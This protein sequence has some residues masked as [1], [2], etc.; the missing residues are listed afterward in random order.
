MRKYLFVFLL[1]S[2]IACTNKSN[3]EMESDLPVIDLEKEYPIKRIDIHEIADVEYIPLE[4]I[5]ESILMFGTDKSV[6]DEYIIVSEF[7]YEYK[8]LIFTRNGKYVSTI[9]RQGQGPGEYINFVSFEVDFEKKELFVRT[10]TVA[11]KILVYTLDGKY[12]REFQLPSRNET[13][14]FEFED[15]YNYDSNYLITYNDMYWPSPKDKYYREPDKTPYYLIN[16]K[17]GSI[18]PIDERLTIDTPIKSIFGMGMGATGHYNIRQ[19]YKISHLVM[20]GPSEAL[21]V[22]NS[23]D[24]IYSYKNHVLEPVAIRTP[25]TASMNPRCFIDPCVFTDK[26]FIYRRVEMIRDEEKEQKELVAYDNRR[27]PIYIMYWETGEIFRLEL[28]DSNLGIKM[29]LY[30]SLGN[31]LFFSS[32]KKNQAGAHYNTTFLFDNLEKNTY[33]GKLK[34]VVSNMVEDDNLVAVIYKFK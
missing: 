10:A 15:L 22:E 14:Y 32:T 20:N 21:I 1:I 16:K 2:L 11:P 5:D 12:L 25:E 3:Q 18:K 7:S 26:Y 28:Y 34:E 6:S 30:A 33:K 19:G 24:T 4:T 31:G 23:L 8:I 27:S 29:P 9:D 17:D 13:H